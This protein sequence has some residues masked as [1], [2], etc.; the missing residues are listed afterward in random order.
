L[1]FFLAGGAHM[2]P[3]GLGSDKITHPK[4]PSLVTGQGFGVKGLAKT[5]RIK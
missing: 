2:P 4:I 3:D 1:G 5:S